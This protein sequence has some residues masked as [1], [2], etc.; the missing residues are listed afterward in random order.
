MTDNTRSTICL[1]NTKTQ[2]NGQIAQRCAPSSSVLIG[3]LIQQL[4]TIFE[5]DKVRRNKLYYGNL[6][7]FSLL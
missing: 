3:S 7:F 6:F 5:S 4:C 2:A 1:N